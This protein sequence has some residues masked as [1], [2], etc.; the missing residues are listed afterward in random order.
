MTITKRFLDAIWDF[1]ARYPEEKI[2]EQTKDCLADYFACTYMGVHELGDKE[3]K[4]IRQQALPRGNVSLIGLGEKCG[5]LEAAM[6]NAMNA[7]APELDDGHR[8]AMIHLG[9]PVISAVLA[10]CQ[11]RG[12]DGVSLLRGII[13]SYEATVR[14]AASMQPRHKLKGYHTTATCTT[15]GTALGLA[16]ALGLPRNQWNAVITAAAT[17]AAGLLE[18]GDNGSELKPYNAGR[19]AVAAVNAFRVGTMG[20]CGPPDILGGPRGFFKAMAGD[21]NQEILLK[22]TMPVL[23]IENIYRKPYASCRHAHAP[24]EAALRIREAHQL[25]PEAIISVIVDTYGM[26]VKGH[27]HRDVTGSASAKMSIPYAVAAAL[28]KGRV[29]A[30]QYEQDSWKDEAVLSLSQKVQVREDPELSALVPGKRAAVV[31]VVMPENRYSCRVDHPLGEPE[32]PMDR[33]MV[34]EK[35]RSLM[36]VAGVDSVR[37]EEILS[38]IY[39]IEGRLDR[40]WDIV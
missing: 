27:D 40:L 8:F 10:V 4:W 39:N 14:L 7:H 34:E 36:A 31:T 19:A 1:S 22:G 5:I 23:A 26:A 37:A 2:M 32:N 3:K 29:D 12:L 18:A 24:I 30:L 6:L 13:V 17:D 16:A 9:A 21:V 15:V 25:D 11:D 33:S 20:L 28:Q 35:Y 38:C